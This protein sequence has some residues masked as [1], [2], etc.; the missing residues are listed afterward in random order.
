MEFSD[1]NNPAAAAR[2]IKDFQKRFSA[3][4]CLSPLK[5]CKGGII[6]AHTLSV[7]A[8][9]RPISRSGLVYA[10]S[11]DLYKREEGRP[12]KLE[13]KGLRETSVFNGFCAAHDKLLFAPIED[14]AFVCSPKQLFLYAYR[15]VAKESYLKRKQAEGFVSPE[16]VKEIH[17]IS[18]D[19]KLQ[20]SDIALLHQ[21]ASLRG[22]EEIERFKEKLDK[23]LLAEDWRRLITTVIPFKDS[24]GLVCNF[25]Y[26]PDFDF[27]G[28]YLQDFLDWHTD[29][30]HLMVTI[31]PSNSGGYVLLS[32]LDTAN[33]SPRKVITS[34]L[35]QPDI[36]SSLV[37]LIASHT[38]NLAFGPD[39]F[40]GLPEEERKKIIDRSFA[41][42]DPFN[43]SVNMLKDCSLKIPGW[44]MEESFTL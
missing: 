42:M 14:N 43:Q 11:L 15:A 6:S 4:V 44:D 19:I 33:Q 3:K 24:P 1:I 41:S 22:A 20:F 27:E 36:T 2:V 40:D 17:G 12:V 5:G 10:F 29:L 31:L 35:N 38:E 7:G 25:V 39:W 26:S 34:L 21:A 37:W 30:D 28:N 16:Q 8:M 13:L 32:Y 9:L 18:P 23:I